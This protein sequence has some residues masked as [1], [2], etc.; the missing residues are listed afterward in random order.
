MTDIQFQN[1]EFNLLE[2]NDVSLNQKKL[3]VE[4]YINKKF[5]IFWLKLYGDS[6]GETELE[7]ATNKI[8][9]FLRTNNQQAILAFEL[10]HTEKNF[11][12]LAGFLNQNSLKEQAEYIKKHKSLNNLIT[13]IKNDIAKS[14]MKIIH[15]N[16]LVYAFGLGIAVTSSNMN[17]FT[18]TFETTLKITGFIVTLLYINERFNDIVPDC[19]KNLKK[20]NITQSTPI[21]ANDHFLKNID[22]IDQKLLNSIF[23]YYPQNNNNGNSKNSDEN[24]FNDYYSD[25][26]NKSA[27]FYLNDTKTLSEKSQEMYTYLTSSISEFDRDTK[28]ALQKQP[29]QF[30]IVFVKRVEFIERENEESRYKNSTLNIKKLN[31]KEASRV[32]LHEFLNSRNKELNDF[33]IN[34]RK[35]NNNFSA[36]LHLFLP[37]IGADA[38]FN[39]STIFEAS[40]GLI[41]NLFTDQIKDLFKDISEKIIIDSVNF[42]DNFVKNYLSPNKNVS[43]NNHRKESLKKSF[44]L[45]FN[46]IREKLIKLN[47][48]ISKSKINVP[49]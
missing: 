43:D 8:Y 27:R 13:N 48:P 11:N 38:I 42:S 4:K 6:Y 2:F 33:K 39:F 21:H 23:N 30:L 18:N 12:L 36:L 9:Y 46:H 37:I 10:W 41:K 1:Q 40:N 15:K 5:G 14:A 35:S 29:I 19:L 31:R 25:I 28:R 22:F 49:R 26:Q 24:R 7:K 45:N 20:S 44:S 16:S 3:I 34:A 32:V 47:E 17:S